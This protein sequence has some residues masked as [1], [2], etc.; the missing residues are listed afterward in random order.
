METDTSPLVALAWTLADAGC[1]V[2]FTASSVVL[3]SALIGGAPGLFGTTT[4]VL[5]GLLV[6]L[7][8][9][10]AVFPAVVT[11][12]EPPYHE[13]LHVSEEATPVSD[14]VLD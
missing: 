7:K 1:A 12:A 5:V 13:R 10:E 2:L 9:S 11:V 14:G 6:Y 4:L 8:A 3:P